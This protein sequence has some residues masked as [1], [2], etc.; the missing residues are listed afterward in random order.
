M[1]TT[2]VLLVNLAVVLAALTVLWAISVAVR[3]TSI[4]DIAWGLAFVL[5]AWVTRFT[6]DG[7]APRQNLLVALTTIW[8][9]RLALHLARRNLGHGEDPRY[10]SMRRRNGDAWRWRSLFTVFWLQGLL[11]WIVSLPVQLGQIPDDRGAFAIMAV[12]GTI[13]WAVGLGFEAVGDAQLAA[14]KR[15]PATAGTVMDRGLWRYTRHPNY[16]GD[17]CVWWGLFLIAASTPLGSWGVIGAIVMNVLLVRVSGKALLERHMARSRPGYG[18]YVARTSGFF[19]RPPRHT[20][21]P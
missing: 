6:A 13:V 21:D 7:W 20:P 17:A 12:L 10:A 19:P 16:F 18:D 9:L 5:I 15:D 14:F 2:G 8:G 11:A 1:S 3:D 4:V